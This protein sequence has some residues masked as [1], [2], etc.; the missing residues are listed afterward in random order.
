[1]SDDAA[2]VATAYFD[3]W[4]VNDFDTMRSLVAEDVN[5]SGPLATLEGAEDYM[6][7]IR[8]MSRIK[9]DIII[10]KV[11]VDGPDVLTWFDLHTSV[12]SP[13]PV[14]NW[15]HVEGGEITDLQNVTYNK[16]VNK[17]TQGKAIDD[18]SLIILMI[19]YAIL[20][21]FGVTG[22]GLVCAVVAR[23]PTMRTGR[24]VYIINLAVSDLL[25]CLIT[26]PFSLV[27]ISVKF[28][29]LGESRCPPRN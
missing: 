29:P 11:F 17:F 14:A 12:A 10:H 27:E 24:N 19:A 26:M 4:K 22:N 7:G 1:M 2:R 5:F 20:I 23:K 16:M 28:W 6:A 9:T 18:T 15:L 8:G 13:V 25:L 21:V 3:A